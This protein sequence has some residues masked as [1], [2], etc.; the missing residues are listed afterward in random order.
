MTRLSSNLKIKSS[1]DETHTIS[2]VAKTNA[3]ITDNVQQIQ[4]AMN[5]IT[6]LQIG[7]SRLS[8]VHSPL[9]RMKDLA[10]QSLNSDLNG[11]LLMQS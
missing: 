11:R 9:I 4:S 3:Q 6:I 10:T 1:Q 5:K 7:E 2:E 8:E